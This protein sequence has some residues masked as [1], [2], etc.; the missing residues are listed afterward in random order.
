M[1]VKISPLE[2]SHA[3]E[4]AQLHIQCI[5]TGFISSL[6]LN[7]VTSLY[8]SIAQSESCFGCV[9]QKDQQVIG[10]VAF[11]SDLNSLYR[12]V[13]KNK[14]FRFALLLTKKMFSWK[15]VKKIFQTLFYPR[16]V[17]QLDLP[18]AELLSVAVA[19]D[20]QGQGIAN[21]LIQ[22]GL[23]QCSRHGLNDVKVLVAA[24]NGPANKLYKKNGFELT[25]QILSHQV[26]SNLYIRKV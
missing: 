22:N 9:A 10:F 1:T 19:P 11:T 4:V 16:R 5:S 13:I 8:E 23:Q 17:K 21:Q 6:G 14:G 24:D 26:L 15:N 7:F 2:C 18:P 3:R 25:S 20:Q 12:S